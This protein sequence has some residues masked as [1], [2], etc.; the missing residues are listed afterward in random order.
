VQYGFVGAVWRLIERGGLDREAINDVLFKPSLTWRLDRDAVL[1]A[2]PEDL[3]QSPKL[4]WKYAIRRRRVYRVASY[5][6]V[7]EIFRRR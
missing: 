1:A 7:K 3:A 5:D 4:T 6:A 2:T